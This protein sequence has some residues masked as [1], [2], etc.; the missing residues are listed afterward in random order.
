MCDLNI[1]NTLGTFRI[2]L[3]NSSVL[4]DINAVEASCDNQSEHILTR[5]IF[6]PWLF[7]EN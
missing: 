2:F 4:R 1:P 5:H 7:N 3:S 6:S